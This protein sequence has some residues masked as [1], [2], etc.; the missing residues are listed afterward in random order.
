MKSSPVFHAAVCALSGAAYGLGYQLIGWGPLAWVSISPALW[1]CGRS[2]PG[3]A[4]LYG[5][6]FGAAS[7]AAG[8]PWVAS[9]I[10]QFLNLPMAPAAALFGVFALGEGLQFA[11]A[12]GLARWAAEGLQLRL[13]LSI[14]SALALAVPPFW[15][16]VEW[17][18]P[19]Q[20]PKYMAMT[21]LFHLPLVQSLD[22]FGTA[23]LTWLICGF[24]V[25][26]YAAF[27]DPKA[28]RAFAAMVLLAAA[29]E[30]Y[31]LLRMRQ[32]DAEVAR[33]FLNGDMIRIGVPQGAQP[34]MPNSL[35]TSR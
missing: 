21:Q 33:K 14:P 5:W 34:P 9:T 18:Y 19:E 28:R 11:L 13:G 2:R 30:G 20:F 15:V 24:N 27:C 4:F 12:L 7:F 23:G 22:L 1:V 6:L 16:A 10:A 32:V 8:C 35:S 26:L 3:Q 31:G 29:N 17:L 25:A